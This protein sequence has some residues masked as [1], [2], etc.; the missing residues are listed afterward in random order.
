MTLTVEAPV[1]LIDPIEPVDPVD[2]ETPAAPGGNAGSETSAGE[3]DGSLAV[4]GGGS[5]IPLAALGVLLS[6]LGVAALVA[7]RRK[8]SPKA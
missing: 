5:P 8:A 3:G 1:A 2:Q 6:V 4:T 7:R